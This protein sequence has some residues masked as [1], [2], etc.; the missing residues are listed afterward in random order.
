[1]PTWISSRV[2]V[3]LRSNATHIEEYALKFRPKPS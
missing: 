3:V 1:V 2:A